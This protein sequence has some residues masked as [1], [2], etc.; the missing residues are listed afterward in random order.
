MFEALEG[1]GRFWRG[2]LHG[3]ST[4]SD[5]ALSP[6]EVCARYREEGYD[7]VAVSDHFLA[8][9]DFPV[10]DT[11]SCR[12]DGFTTLLGA[13]LHPWETSRGDMWHLVA[14]GLPAD[15]A[16]T[17]AEETGPEIARRAVEAGAFVALAHPLWSQL[18]EADGLA[19]EA[20]HAVEVYNHKSML[21]VDRGEGLYLWDALLHAG[22]RVTAIASDDSHWHNA[23]AFGGWV[24]VKAAE[25]TPEALLSALK[26]GAF[27]ASQGPEIQG[28]AR[29][30]DMLEVTC[31]PAISIILAGPLSWRSRALGSGLTRARL[32]IEP[33]R[34]GWR[35]LI[36]RDAQGRRA[37]SNPFWIEG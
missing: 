20:A 26:R 3:H 31:S 4:L 2:N 25:N 22:R 37:W 23:D 14:V 16:P 6:E 9:F 33:E 27:Y 34:G 18:T 35:R 13:E 12:V 15:F 7:F 10:T 5:G 11:T 8:R 17:G 32:A 36:V 30:G 21:E 1:E 19:V 28:V 29:D 24:M